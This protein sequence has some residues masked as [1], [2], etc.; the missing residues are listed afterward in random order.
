MRSLFKKIINHYRVPDDA[1]ETFRH[2]FKYGISKGL[3]LAGSAGVAGVILKKSFSASDFQVAL[4]YSATNLGLLFSIFTAVHA[5]RANKMNYAY[6]PDAIARTLFILTAV[7]TALIPNAWLFTAILCA[8]Y[9]FNSLNT[10]VLTSIYRSNYPD[11]SRGKVMG[12]VRTV[13]NIAFVVASYV[14]GLMLDL[15]GHNYVY[16]YPIIGL[17][18]LWGGW[19]LRKIKIVPTVHTTPPMHPIR[20]ALTILRQDKPFA[21]FMGY[22][23]IFGFAM[24]MIDPVK[25]IYVTDPAYGINATYEEAVLAVTVIPQAVMLLTFAFWGRQIDKYGVIKIR[26]LLNILPTINVILFYFATDLRLIYFA[27]FL[28]GISMSGAQLS[29]QLCVMEFAP[30]QQVGLY[31]GIHTMLT[32]LRGLVAPFIGAWLIGTSGMGNTFLFAAGLMVISTVMM[33][34][35]SANHIRRD[36]EAPLPIAAERGD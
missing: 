22:W 32:G 7:A 15:D 9:A 14:F 11:H 27:S 34:R 29:W 19:Q 10:P 18:G 5:E 16:V 35:F 36:I 3:V 33:I 12:I 20:S 4:L 8:A 2:D 21:H 30:R 1:Y 23:A 6:V 17:V 26:F 13:F 31:M 24:L 25:T 28:Q